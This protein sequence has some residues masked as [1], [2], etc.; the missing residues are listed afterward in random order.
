V[1]SK[2][3]VSWCA[4]LR[5]WWRRYAPLSDPPLMTHVA[6]N[7]SASN[8]QK[9]TAPRLLTD[10][11]TINRGSRLGDIA[12]TR[13]IVLTVSNY[14]RY[15]SDSPLFFVVAALLFF[16]CFFFLFPPS[17]CLLTKQNLVAWVR[18]LQL[19]LFIFGLRS[20]LPIQWIRPESY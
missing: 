12:S 17:F 15:I 5:L 11:F 10:G 19:L 7:V 14:T 9:Q 4:G 13:G 6:A 8:K 18:F 3:E 1:T 20:A 2:A 16:E